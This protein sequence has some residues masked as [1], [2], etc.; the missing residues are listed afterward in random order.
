MPH[1]YNNIVLQLQFLITSFD[2]GL[3][4]QLFM[5]SFNLNYSIIESLSDTLSVFFVLDICT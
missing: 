5:S 1:G 4:K 2:L 3:W